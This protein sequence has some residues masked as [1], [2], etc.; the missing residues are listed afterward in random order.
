MDWST[1]KRLPWDILYLMGGGIAIA[2]DRHHLQ[3]GV[4]QFDPGG[5]GQGPAVGCMQCIE[6][7]IGGHAA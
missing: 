2:H 5:K 6:I 3:I 4:R 7:N 1:A